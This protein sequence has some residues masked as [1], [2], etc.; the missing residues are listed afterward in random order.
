MLMKK[1]LLI[2]LVL[3]LVVAG[4]VPAL[5]V[6]LSASGYIGMAGVLFRNANAAPPFA[7]YT[8]PGYR[9]TSPMSAFNEQMGSTLTGR[10]QLGFTVRASEDLYGFVNFRMNSNGNNR[11]GWNF[12]PNWG[13][14]G[15]GSISVEISDLY[16][17]FRVPPNLPL[18]FRIGLQA[19]AIRPWIFCYMMDPAV[20]ARVM[21]D[22]IKLSVTSY[23]AKIR[24]PSAT[25]ATSSAEFYAIDAKLPLAFDSVNIAPGIF[26]AFQNQRWALVTSNDP[27]AAKKYWLG[28]NVDGGIGPVKMQVDFIYNFGTLENRT[29]ADQNYNSFLINGVFSFVWQKLEVGVAGLYVKGENDATNTIES[30]QLPGSGTYGSE[31]MAVNADFVVFNNG[32]MMPGPGWPANVGLIDGPSTFWFGYWDIRGF[33]YFQAL[34][35]LKIGA[36]VGYIGDT[37]SGGD[38][39]GTDADDDGNIGWEMDFGVNVQIY[40]NLALHSAFGYL[41]AG[42]ALSQA[43]GV[44][45]S[46]PWGWQTRLMYMF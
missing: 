6:D 41:F 14:E 1:A 12:T 46:D 3:G 7:F 18:W 45:P 11:W 13:Q 30:F 34:D 37:V 27:D 4:A 17:D 32:W 25:E 33:V 23:F 20:S 15:A 24:D 19:V 35:W 28:I 9:H 42:K 40:K 44:K 26:F 29:I 22:P 2:G 43:G 5:A 16:M 36:Q 38:A 31:S 21:I 10:T 8:P 39:I